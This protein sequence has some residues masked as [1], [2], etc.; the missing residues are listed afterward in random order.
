MRLPSVRHRVDTQ[1]RKARSRIE[2]KLVPSGPAVTRHLALP[3]EGRDLDWIINEMD[4]MDN[5]AVVNVNWR[6]G[7]LSGIVYHGG[8]DIEVWKTNCG[9]FEL[10]M[11]TPTR[12][13]EQK[14]V[15][16]AVQK[17]IFS[18][19]LHPDAFPGMV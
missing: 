11:L 10:T 8:E 18:N 4:Q 13:V 9:D 15:N 5:E 7:K 1:M 6:H 3:R 14:V 17:Y 16:A 2:A 19:P 12:G